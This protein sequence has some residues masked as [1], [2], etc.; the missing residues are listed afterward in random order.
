MFYYVITFTISLLFVSL[1]SGSF[2]K[3]KKKRA[4]L[5]SA[6]SIIILCLFAGVRADTV[7]IDV[8]WYALPEF[9]SA[10]KNSSF[11]TYYITSNMDLLYALL[12]FISSRLSTDM[13]LLLFLSQ[14][15]VAMPI[16][17]VAYK[18][19]DSQSMVLSMFIYDFLFFNRSLSVMR[20]SIACAL[21]L[22]AYTCLEER[23]RKK[24]V[25]LCIL[26]VFFHISS[27]I[28]ILIFVVLE[29]IIKGKHS[30]I[31]KAFTAGFAFLVVMNIS[32]IAYFF[33][34]NLG[35]FSTFY[36]DR[37]AARISTAGLSFFETVCRAAFVFIPILIMTYKGDKTYKKAYYYLTVIGFI[38][39]FA[40][41]TSEYL[42]RI[43]YYFQFFYLLTLPSFI[44][45]V[46]PRNGSKFILLSAVCGLVLV[47][48]Y[49]IYIGWNW[50]GTM[51]YKFRF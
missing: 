36:Y 42:I 4:Y 37:L 7:G 19:R 47:Y 12:I 9:N 18:K 32:N 49:I 22:L 33:I 11:F 23:K 10:L 5:Y 8:E 24:F 16:Y 50:H 48:W 27:L 28:P 15:L 25:L 39:S 13:G 35:V 20:Q 44:K 46:S 2:H 31:K 41:L 14:L 1:A 45:R 3:G 38:L 26:S 30:I 51:P 17:V 43:G 29:F 6:I 34:Y 21:L 40:A